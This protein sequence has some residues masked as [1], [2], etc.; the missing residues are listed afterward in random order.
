MKLKQV[1]KNGSKKSNKENK[2]AVLKASTPVYVLGST[3]Q[4]GLASSESI[5]TSPKLCCYNI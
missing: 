5:I 4:L 3:D 2:K 1:F